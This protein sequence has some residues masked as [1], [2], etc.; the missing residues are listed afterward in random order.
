MQTISR[1]ETNLNP[2]SDR[3][4]IIERTAKLLMS[5]D[6]RDWDTAKRLLADT[7]NYTAFDRNEPE[8]VSGTELVTRW[9]HM[10]S[11]LDATQHLLGTQVVTVDGTEATC[12]ANMQT[13]ASFGNATGDPTWTIGGRYDF[14]LIRTSSGWL[15]NAMALTAQWS[16][17]NQQIMQPPQE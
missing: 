14:G 12:A 2:L 11:H 13:T 9:Q 15:I 8:V 7:V 16:D 4:E 17:G 5:V 10:L 3:Q 6:A 1:T